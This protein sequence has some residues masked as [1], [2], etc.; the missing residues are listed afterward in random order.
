MRGLHTWCGLQLAWGGHHHPLDRAGVLAL[1]ESDHRH[2]R[3]RWSRWER[4]PWRLERWALQDRPIGTD[5]QAVRRRSS[6]RKR[7]L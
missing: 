4:L 6:L 3:L 1:D 5:E 2:P 7:E